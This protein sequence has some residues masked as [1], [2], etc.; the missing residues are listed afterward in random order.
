MTCDAVSPPRAIIIIIMAGAK[1]T[2]PDYEPA[3]REGDEMRGC[4]A[5][6]SLREELVRIM[7]K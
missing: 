6:L 5:L 2:G 4:A 7:T 1:K 3:R